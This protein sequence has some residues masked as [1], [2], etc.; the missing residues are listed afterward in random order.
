MQLD[1]KRKLSLHFGKK[2]YKFLSADDLII[3]VEYSKESKKFL[4]TARP[5]DTSLT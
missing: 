2:K 5:Q 1:K 3:Y 4:I